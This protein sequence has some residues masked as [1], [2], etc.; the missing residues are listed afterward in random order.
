MRGEDYY[1]LDA[2]SL[3]KA[4]GNVTAMGTVVRD[5]IL[6]EELTNTWNPT[7]GRQRQEDW[8]FTVILSYKSRSACA[9]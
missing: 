1:V 4:H 2:G 3:L 8:E 7:L 6:L 5:W 9:T